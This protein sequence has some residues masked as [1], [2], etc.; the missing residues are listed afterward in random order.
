[1]LGLTLGLMLCLATG[2][3]VSMEEEY[4]VGLSGWFLL[5]RA[6]HFSELDRGREVSGIFFFG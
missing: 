3:A 6:D 5:K 4:A 2:G 1:M